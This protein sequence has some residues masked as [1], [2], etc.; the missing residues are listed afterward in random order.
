MS[1]SRSTPGQK[2]DNGWDVGVRKTIDA[3]PE[4]V[5][6]YLVG[7][8]LPAWLGDIESLPSKKGVRYQ[9]RDGV[10]GT[11]RAFVAGKQVR[12]SW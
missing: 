3:S 2:N 10:R 5:W 11:V 12:L 4:T 6:K 7:E 1:E 9:T 8:G